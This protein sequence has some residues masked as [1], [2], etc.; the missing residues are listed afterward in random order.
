M[1]KN[2]LALNE[3]STV[4]TTYRDS[5]R[6]SDAQLKVGLIY[7]AQSKWSDAKSSFKQVINHYPGTAPARV[8]SEQLKQIKTS[9]H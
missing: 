4:V 9:G 3:F 5:P 1:G 2:D 7:S 8:A 6:V